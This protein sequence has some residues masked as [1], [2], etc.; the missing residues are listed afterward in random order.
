M[1]K[2]QNVEKWGRGAARERYGS[3]K[4]SGVTPAPSQQGVQDP[5]AK[6][7]SGYDNDASGWVRG[8]GSQSPHP[9]FDGR[10]LRNK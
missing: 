2:I 8:M 10:R 4:D 5:E 9:H 7:G 3:P 6:H 1:A